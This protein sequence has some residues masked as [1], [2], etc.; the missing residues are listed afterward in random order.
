MTHSDEAHGADSR[1]GMT[2]QER[3]RTAMLTSALYDWVPL[4]EVKTAIAQYDLAET[5]AA[6]QDLALQTIRSL[7]EDGL[8][9]IGELPGPDDEEFPAWDLSIDAAMERVYDRFV[10]HYGD[11]EL[12]EFCIWLG[13]T[14]SGR[15]VAENF[16]SGSAR[17]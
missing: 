14:E 15:R 11:P 10:R 4:I 5:L 7:L 16:E 8:M 13:L 17:D 6:Q 2:A 1:S 12:W 3:L 9:Q